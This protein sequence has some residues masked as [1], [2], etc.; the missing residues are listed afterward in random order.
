MPEAGVG[1]GELALKNKGTFWK[2]NGYFNCEGRCIHLSKFKIYQ[3]VDLKPMHFNYSFIIYIS[4]YN[5]F[6]YFKLYIMTIYI[7][8]Q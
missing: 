7:T 6:I 3:N 4:N 2:E 5:I 8:P 1:V